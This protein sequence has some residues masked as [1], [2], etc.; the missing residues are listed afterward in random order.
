MNMVID[1][2]VPLNQTTPVYPGDPKAK[3]VPA[4]TIEKN[5]W[6]DHTLSLN[7]HLGTH[8]DAPAHMLSSGKTLDQYT[9]DK[10]I[11][12]GVYVDVLDHI[13]DVSKLKRI[14]IKPDDIVLLHTNMIKQYNSPDYYQKYP[15]V[16]ENFA[17][18]LV[19]QKVSMVGMDMCGP[20]YPPFPIHKL[21]LDNDVL[22]IENMT[23]IDKLAS[24]TFSVSALPLNL[25]LDG[26]PA[27]VIAT[28]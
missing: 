26:S 3:M 12:R 14:D 8:I 5:G 13:F 15:R 19:E 11:G 18:Y 16:T 22:I 23:N 24:K 25:S 9:V 21:L 10:F 1:L 7:T 28:V 20:D 2:T 27:R 6:L 4:G 17:K